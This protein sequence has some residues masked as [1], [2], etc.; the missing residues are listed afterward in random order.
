M[1][2]IEL[3]EVVFEKPIK[4]NSESTGRLVTREDEGRKWSLSLQMGFVTV[5]HKPTGAT[6]MVPL[7]NVTYMIPRKQDEAKAAAKK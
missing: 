4:M 6:C 1:E 2:K 3:D 7:A 5:Q